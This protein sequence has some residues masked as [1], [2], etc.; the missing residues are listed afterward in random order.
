MQSNRRGVLLDS[1]V[2]PGNDS[3]AWRLQ[4][5]AGAIIAP[6]FSISE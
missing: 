4:T 2:K 6:A 1:L 5:K 3:G